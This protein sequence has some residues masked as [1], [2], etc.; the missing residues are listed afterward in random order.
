ME[1]YL[2][3]ATE[4]GVFAVGA[5][6]GGVSSLYFPG[7]EAT[8]AL[9]DPGPAALAPHDSARHHAERGVEALLRY[10]EG[11]TMGRI[12]LDLSWA[13]PFMGDVY[14]ALLTVPLGQTV[15]YGE[16]AALAGHSGAQR[17]VGGAMKRNRLPLFVPCHRVLAAQGRIG[18]WSGQAG[19]KRRILGHEGVCFSRGGDCISK[20]GEL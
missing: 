4:W 20:S 19:W 10:V 5:T 6:G 14:R 16:L 2:E 17:A 13:T 8:A 15:S 18:G 12:P 9:C 11:G 3:A 1:I 7:T